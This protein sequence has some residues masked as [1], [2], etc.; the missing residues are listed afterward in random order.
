MKKA[1]RI[2]NIDFCVESGNAG[3]ISFA[4]DSLSFLPQSEDASFE[5]ILNVDFGPSLN[6]GRYFAEEKKGCVL[7][8]N[9][10]FKLYSAQ[11]RLVYDPF[12]LPWL[13]FCL[14][15]RERKLL[16]N[17]FINSSSRERFKG[18]FQKGI[19]QEKFYYLIRYLA[20]FIILYI[21]KNEM[22]FALVHGS[23]VEKDGEGYLFCGL[24]GCGKSSLALSSVSGSGFKLLS[25]N[26]LLVKDG[27]IYSFADML[28]F[29]SF[30]KGIAGVSGISDSGYMVKGKRFYSLDKN[31]LSPRA[32]LKS[33]YIIC[34]A[35]DNFIRGIAAQEFLRMK[36]GIDAATKEFFE[37]SFI[38]IFSLFDA[39]SSGMASGESLGRS[40]PGADCYFA[41][42]RK[43][44]IGSAFI[45]YLISARKEQAEA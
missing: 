30:D 35:E 45:E 20:H 21:A 37:Y 26:F 36:N 11:N 39:F 5:V 28:R 14:E 13:S 23:A 44:A 15:R 1:F 42:V 19:L 43:G 32:K 31:R 8:A 7:F 12:L 34:L 2:Y 4:Q 6:T 22:G 29:S 41:G 3:F 24:P 18:L 17:A 10:A 33:A 40:L 27:F 9:S 25:D 16:I 38:D